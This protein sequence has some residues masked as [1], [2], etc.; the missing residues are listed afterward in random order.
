M[1]P[2]KSFGC[3]ICGKQAPKG[4]RKDGKFEERMS[5]LMSH[6]KRYHPKAHKKSIEKGLRTRYG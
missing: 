3:S 6:K 4:L 5:W 1:S 2:L